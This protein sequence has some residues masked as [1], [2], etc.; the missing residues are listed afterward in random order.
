[1]QTLSLFSTLVSD[2]EPISHLIELQALDLDYTKVSDLRPIVALSAL[3]N[4]DFSRGLNFMNTPATKLDRRLDELAKIENHHE[5]TRETLAYLRTLPPW[6]EPYTPVATPDGSPPQAIGD[7]AL[8]QARTLSDLTPLAEELLQNPD[9]GTFTAR[10]KPIEKPD[11]LSGTLGIVADA[12]EDVL[13]NPNNGLNAASLDIRKLR[14]TIERYGNDPQR[15]EMDFTTAHGS[16]TRLIAVDELPPSDE[17]LALL[18]ALEEGAMGI[19]ATDTAVAVNRRILQ[20]QKL[21]EMS[22]QDIAKIAEAAPV[23]EAITEGDTQQ[24]MHEDVPA[25]VEE[26]T[27]RRPTLPGVTRADAILPARDEAVRVFGRSA[28]MTIM[29]RKSPD[30]LKKIEQSSGYKAASIMAVLKSL[31]DIGLGLFNIFKG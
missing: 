30:M 15:I 17:N 14:R 9:T 27:A 21:R 23:L 24:Q 12:I 18:T 8:E 29:L 6:P 3:G 19:R 28:R 5:R 31:V 13:L 1:L 11:L 7:K 22:A 26:L 25:L 4:G 2:L 20:E 16:I 10:P